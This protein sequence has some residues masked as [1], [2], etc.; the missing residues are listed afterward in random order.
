MFKR[1]WQRFRDGAGHDL[2]ELARRL[3]VSADTLSA[4]SVFYRGFTRPK[5]AGGKRTIHSPERPL[6]DMQRRVLHRL[7]GHLRVHPA[8]CGFRRGQSIVD[9]AAPHVRRAVIMKLDLTDFFTATS[10]G[11][12][13]KYFRRIGWNRPAAQR[14]VELTC[15]GG[16]LPQGA[17]TSPI[18][19]NLVNYR[20]DARLE[21]LARA[22]GAR[23]T[24]Y[25]DDITFSFDRDNRAVIAV[26]RHSAC[27]V[28]EEFGYVVNRTKG[29]HILRR[30]Q[31]QIVTGLVVNH[32]ANLPRQTR[33]WLRAVEHRRRTKGEATLN[34]KQIA[35]WKAL[36]A[37]IARAGETR[38]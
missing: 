16:G 18:L 32:R 12:V 20:L 6:R 27:R 19:S 9:N 2:D 38:T 24:R 1:L 17:P 8:A 25:A 10:T 35:G 21:G 15:H 33:R 7:L 37:M 26:V 3:D 5:R 4:V 29:V 28:I 11:R 23:Y 31:R 36:S 30:H 14:L 22:K 13:Q 34:D